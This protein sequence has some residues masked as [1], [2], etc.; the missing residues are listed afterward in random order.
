MVGPNQEAVV[1]SPISN[2]RYRET[3]CVVSLGSRCSTIGLHP[4][5]RELRLTLARL[6]IRVRVLG[7]QAILTPSKGK[8]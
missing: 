1:V 8:Q 7:F 2:V 3:E 5:I 6:S 4:E